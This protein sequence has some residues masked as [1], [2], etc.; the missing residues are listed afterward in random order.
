VNGNGN[1]AAGLGTDDSSGKSDP[2][3]GIKKDLFEKEILE[4]AEEIL[5]ERGEYKAAREVGDAL[6]RI[7][8]EAGEG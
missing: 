7:Q 4:T 1:H 6:A 2:R 8:V 3:G 5:E